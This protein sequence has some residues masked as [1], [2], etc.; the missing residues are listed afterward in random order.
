MPINIKE[1]E[2]IEELENGILKG[3]YLSGHEN[4]EK[5]PILVKMGS[6]SQCN[7]I[8]FQYHLVLLVGEY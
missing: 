2:A 7:V 8:N 6:F 5:D 3:E 1:P 4:C